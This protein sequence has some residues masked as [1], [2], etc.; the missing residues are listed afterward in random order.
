MAATLQH[1][2]HDLDGANASSMGFVTSAPNTASPAPRSAP[3]A[4]V[5]RFL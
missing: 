3:L 4:V 5:L 2:F 1:D